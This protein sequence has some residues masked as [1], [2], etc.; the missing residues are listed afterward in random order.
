M[1]LN[2]IFT[3]PLFIDHL[4]V[5]NL[6]LVNYCYDYREKFPSKKHKSGYQSF[7]LTDDNTPISELFKE[8][9]SRTDRVKNEFYSLKESVKLIN[10]SG[11]FN[12]NSPGD[13]WES[14]SF[15]HC[16]SLNFLTCV[17][18]PKAKKDC[19]DIVLV[20]PD[21]AL[22][23]AIPNQIKNKLYVSNTSTWHVSPEDG[24]LLIFPAWIYHYVESN[25]SDEDRISI[26]LNVSLS[27][28]NELLNAPR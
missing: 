17:Y 4:S 25:K 3:T 24:L 10:S 26:V 9:R 27:Y 23:Y 11:W 13:V 14:L 21:R 22:D 19:G 16:H 7:N 15:P 28:D 12:I 2:G 20:S 1:I 8:I 6:E 18:Y 5:D